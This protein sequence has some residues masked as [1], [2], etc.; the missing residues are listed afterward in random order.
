MEFNYPCFIANEC[1]NWFAHWLQCQ[2]INKCLYTNCSICK[3]IS[4]NIKFATKLLLESIY[5]IHDSFTYGSDIVSINIS[6]LT[7]EKAKQ[8]L[9][10]TP[11]INITEYS[12]K[13]LSKLIEERFE[14]I[15]KKDFPGIGN[16]SMDK[17]ILSRAG[18]YSPLM[19]KGGN[20]L[21]NTLSLL[22]KSSLHLPTDIPINRISVAEF[23]LLCFHLNGQYLLTP[24]SV[25]LLWSGAIRL[26]IITTL[27]CQ[28][29]HISY[30]IFKN[31]LDLNI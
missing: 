10:N 7:E 4:N 29:F 14:N 28:D 6:Q 3:Y 8:I 11:F 27:L 15:T 9:D 23:C 20:S 30:E 26:N 16:I 12:D 21:Y 31:L 22:Y 24:N 5:Q 2:K 1:Q 25:S 17:D 18:L 13:Q 19:G